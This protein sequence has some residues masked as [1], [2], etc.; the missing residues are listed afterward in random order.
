MTLPPHQHWYNASTAKLG[1]SI[2]GGFLNDLVR[3]GYAR[4]WWA[5][6]LAAESVS[7]EAEAHRAAA[8]A[9]LQRRS[10]LPSLIADAT[11][12]DHAGAAVSL[13]GFLL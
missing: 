13:Q 12:A 2:F 10:L 7:P 9:D 3:A 6:T 4:C 11:S 8:T 5:R 1:P